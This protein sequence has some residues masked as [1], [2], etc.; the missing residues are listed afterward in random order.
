MSERQ[1]LP[2]PNP[3]NE[4]RAPGA[5]DRPDLSIRRVSEYAE[6]TISTEQRDETLAAREF[7]LWIEELGLKRPYVVTSQHGRT[8]FEAIKRPSAVVT[9]PASA[10]LPYAQAL[11]NEIALS[12]A[13]IVVAIGGGRLLDIAK[14]AAQY[15]ERKLVAAPTQLSHDGICSPVAVLP[16]PEG[17]VRSIAAISPASVF[18]S[19]PTLAQSPAR[20][21][22]AGIGDIISNPFALRDW[23]MAAIRGKDVIVES[24]WHLSMEATHLIEPRLG[25]V[26]TG[27]ARRPEFIG[28]LAHSLTN[29]GFAMRAAG[30]SRPA[31]G[32]EHKISHTIDAKFG[33]RALHGEQVAFA[34]II[35]GALQGLDPLPIVQS[36]ESLG[37]PTRPEH[38]GL[39]REE[40]IDVVLDAP[41]TKP[42]RFTVLENAALGRRS[43][44]AL[45]DDLWGPA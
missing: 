13:E 28:L 19:L 11:G 16:V 39:S 27:G 26:A 20:S 8:L 17:G 15:S 40:M 42:E 31:S 21:I 35:S 9:P 1:N 23:E 18:Y 41:R 45:L 10:D 25:R 30:S 38:L 34:C 14:V 5:T 33:G 32:A 24:A 37:L 43:A 6:V 44:A 29:S 36:L 2:M 12:S 4:V 22:I 7:R 3:E